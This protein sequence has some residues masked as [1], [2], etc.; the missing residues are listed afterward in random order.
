MGLIRLGGLKF[1]FCRAPEAQE[2]E[3]V[4]RLPLKGPDGT[5]T[6][7]KGAPRARIPSVVR[8]SDEARPRPCMLKNAQHHRA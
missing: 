8:A 4:P 1:A 6:Y 5:L 2:E 7:E 3:I